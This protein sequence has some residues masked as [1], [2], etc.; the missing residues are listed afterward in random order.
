[1]QYISIFISSCFDTIS[2]E[3]LNSGI[4]LEHLWNESSNALF[5]VEVI[6]FLVSRWLVKF[7]MRAQ[8]HRFFASILFIFVFCFATKY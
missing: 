3:H 2:Q 8:L 7:A 4:T 5:A 1:M 6:S